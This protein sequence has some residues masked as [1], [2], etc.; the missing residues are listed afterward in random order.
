MYPDKYQTEN[1][2]SNVEVKAKTEGP[3]RVCI[4]IGKTTIPTIQTL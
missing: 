3:E 1:R 4:P 2:D